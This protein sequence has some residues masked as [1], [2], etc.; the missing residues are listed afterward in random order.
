MVDL[1][2]PTSS[3]SQ[4]AFWNTQSSNRK[5]MGSIPNLTTTTSRTNW[6]CKGATT[7]KY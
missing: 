5:I 6:P 3:N 2:P 7:E 1:Q 4:V